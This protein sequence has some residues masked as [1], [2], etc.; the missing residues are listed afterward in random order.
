MSNIEKRW[1]REENALF[2]LAFALHPSFRETAVAIVAESQRKHGNWESK[3]NPLSV[4]RLTHAALF[5]YDTKKAASTG[6]YRI[7][8][9]RGSGES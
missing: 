5:Y 9:Q 6:G 8:A 3:R 4:A 7:G 2:F 1:E